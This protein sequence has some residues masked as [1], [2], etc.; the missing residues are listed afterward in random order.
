MSND[1]KTPSGH[2]Q[3]GTWVGGEVRRDLSPP[4]IYVIGS[5]Q[6]SMLSSRNRA[7][8]PA[9]RCASGM[10]AANLISD[11]LNILIILACRKVPD[12][13]FHSLL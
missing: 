5:V 13:I 6:A 8:V 9:L 12:F 4:G 1:L 3:Q 7:G 2:H 11:H 10:L